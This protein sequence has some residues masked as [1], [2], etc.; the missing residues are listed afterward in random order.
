MIKKRKKEGQKRKRK[1]INPLLKK[2][3]WKKAGRIKEDL[4]F[5]MAGKKALY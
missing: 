2:K 5:A 3:K 4:L 1:G